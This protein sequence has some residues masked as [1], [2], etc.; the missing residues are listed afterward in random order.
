MASVFG[1]TWDVPECGATGSPWDV[2][3]C[4]ATGSYAPMST[5]RM[6]SNCIHCSLM[7]GRH[8]Y[9]T[10]CSFGRGAAGG[11]CH[12]AS[13]PVVAH[14]RAGSLRWTQQHAPP[15]SAGPRTRRSDFPQMP[16]VLLLSPKCDPHAVVKYCCNVLNGGYISQSLVHR[17]VAYRCSANKGLKTMPSAL[18]KWQWCRV[19]QD[20]AIDIS[21]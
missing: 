11:C 6:P 14:A 7:R 12:A 19:N 5:T 10:S 3:E 16:A 9:D 13:H 20:T 17:E 18:N 21:S 4:G 2:P 1:N 8:P 15:R